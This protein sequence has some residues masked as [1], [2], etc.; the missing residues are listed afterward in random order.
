MCDGS[1]M[2]QI[3][4]TPFKVRKEPSIIEMVTVKLFKAQSYLSFCHVRL[5]PTFENGQLT[6]RGTYTKLKFPI[7]VH[8]A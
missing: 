7:V 3:R 1:S 5:Q 4:F 8:I 2:L 6:R